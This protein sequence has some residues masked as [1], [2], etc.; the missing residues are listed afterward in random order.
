MDEIR[1]LK[2]YFFINESLTKMFDE[3]NL[4]FIFLVFCVPKQNI[5]RQISHFVNL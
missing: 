3:V 1:I 5:F 2:L 4:F